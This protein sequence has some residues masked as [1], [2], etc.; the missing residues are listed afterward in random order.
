MEVSNLVVVSVK[1]PDSLDFNKHLLTLHQQVSIGTM[2]QYLRWLQPHSPLSPTCNKPEGRTPEDETEARVLLVHI[3]NNT[4]L[5]VEATVRA[6]P[7]VLDQLVAQ[8]LSALQH[9][10]VL[11]LK[12]IKRHLLPHHLATPHLNGSHLNGP[13]LLQL[14]TPAPF[15]VPTILTTKSRTSTSATGI[16]DGTPKTIRSGAHAPQHDQTPLPEPEDDKQTDR[17]SETNIVP[18]TVPMEP[19]TQGEGPTE[20]LHQADA[21]GLP[22]QHSP[23]DSHQYNPEQ[24]G[25]GKAILG[26]TSHH[27]HHQTHSPT[28]F[29]FPPIVPSKTASPASRANMAPQPPRALIRDALKL[30]TAANGLKS[31][32]RIRVLRVRSLT[33]PR[34]WDSLQQDLPLPYPFYEPQDW[35][36]LHDRFNVAFVAWNPSQSPSKPVSGTPVYTGQPVSTGLPSG[37]REE[38]SSNSWSTMLDNPQTRSTWED[39]TYHPEDHDGKILF[40][41]RRV[42]FGIGTLEETMEEYEHQPFGRISPQGMRMLA[43]SLPPKGITS[44]VKADPLTEEYLERTDGSVRPAATPLKD[45]DVK[46][47]APQT[48]PPIPETFFPSPPILVDD[49][50]PQA[51]LFDP[52]NYASFHPK[53][54]RMAFSGCSSSLSSLAEP[55]PLPPASSPPQLMSMSPLKSAFYLPPPRF[56][57]FDPGTPTPPPRSFCAATVRPTSPRLSPVY[58]PPVPPRMSEPLWCDEPAWEPPAT[59]SPEDESG[60]D[61]DY[62]Q[63]SDSLL[64][65]F[66]AQFLEAHPEYDEGLYEHSPATVQAWQRD[67]DQRLPER[68]EEA[69]PRTEMFAQFLSELLPLL[70]LVHSS[71][72]F[73]SFPNNNQHNTTFPPITPS[74]TTT[75]AAPAPHDQNG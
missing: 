51:T 56:P 33:G 20:I 62:Q 64:Q 59:V 49:D 53:Q 3:K 18:A 21:S 32:A 38:S 19:N 10:R 14:L 71:S 74:A 72:S 25:K 16:T 46:E 23:L 50:L 35:S 6:A 75:M 29:V 31:I 65:E 40:A 41:P 58:Y 43:R 22:S 73:H 63:L 1:P 28:E 69:E 24:A 26:Q 36:D 37:N 55:E 39:Y 68:Q 17:G 12:A 15:P 70:P 57:P 66:Q 54:T 67:V 2:Q 45:A 34:L 30:F 8:D 42:S 4:V 13:H 52:A 7:G 11:A 9:L 48:P 44:P 61:E 27:N 47:D 5:G 60:V